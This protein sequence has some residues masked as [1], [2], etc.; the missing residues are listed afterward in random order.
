MHRFFIQ[1]EN[2]K[3]NTARISGSDINHIKNVLRLNPG[4]DLELFDGTGNVYAAKIKKIDKKEVVCEIASY[5]ESKSEPHVQVTIIQCLPKGPKINLI[6]Q[7]LTEIGVYK[8]I[9]AISERSIPNL[10]EEKMEKKVLRWQRIAKEASEQSARGI[11]PHVMEIK[12]FEKAL[13]E[14]KNAGLK[15]IPWEMEDKRTLKEILK[16]NKKVESISIAIG[17]EGGFSK[18]ETEKAEKAGFIP[19]SL[20]KRILRT[21][22]AGI[23]VLAD[24]LYE[25]ED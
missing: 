10:S 21:E 22:T 14:T 6:I 13:E 18:E 25:L 24:I 3:R 12:P 7:K 16:K 4:D 8:I 1:A 2:I 23:V 19:I 17:P 5:R 11:V 15:L 9:P 20:G